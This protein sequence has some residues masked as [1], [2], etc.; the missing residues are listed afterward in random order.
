MCIYL[1]NT[2]SVNDRVASVKGE[3][4]LVG[5]SLAFK[6]PVVCVSRDLMLSSCREEQVG[7]CV[8]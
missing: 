1:S 6:E 5:L 7:F 4:K 2:K 3:T 8:V